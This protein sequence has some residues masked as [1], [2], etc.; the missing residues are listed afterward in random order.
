MKNE[1][2]DTI[3][4]TD[5][6]R[7]NEELKRRIRDYWDSVPCGTQDVTA[8]RYTPEYFEEIESIRYFREPYIFSF[9]QFSRWHGVKMLEVGVG[10]GTDFLQWVRAGADAHGIDL[11]SVAVEHVQRRLPIYGVSAREVRVADGEYMPYPD[12]EFEMVYSWG[13]IHHTPDTPKVLSEI[14]RVTKPGGVCKVMVHHKGSP[15]SFYL[16]L[17]W[18]LAKGRPWRSF[19]WCFA[20]CV[21]SPGTQA[22]TKREVRKMLRGLPIEDLKFK[23]YKTRQDYAA[24]HGHLVSLLGRIFSTLAGRQSGFYLTVE[25]RKKLGGSERREN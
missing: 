1:V 15:V 16:W 25:F 13:V 6:V 5:A 21:E 10:A 14:V 22:F 18:G 2:T 24:G 4:S 9:A 3:T 17:K 19:N 20:N 23:A 11:S 8:P 12:N 7:P